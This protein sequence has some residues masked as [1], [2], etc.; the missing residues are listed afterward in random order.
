MFV[1][2]DQPSFLLNFI[3][4][5]LN[6][7][8]YGRLLSRAETNYLFNYINNR[9]HYTIPQFSIRDKSILL[10]ELKPK[11]NYMQTNNSYDITSYNIRN[12][13][14]KQP[15]TFE[16]NNLKINNILQF[17]SIPLGN[18]KISDKILG[19]VSNPIEQIT[20]KKQN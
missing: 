10:S 18:N 5:N 16:S 17:N 3:L 1:L 7:N 14:S 8:Y 20:Q 4:E 12:Y 15:I 9:N 19:L 6:K 2:S 11:T 13:L